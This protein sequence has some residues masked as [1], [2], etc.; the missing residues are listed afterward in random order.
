MFDCVS[1]GDSMMDVYLTLHNAEVKCEFNSEKCQICLQYGEKIPVDRMDRGLGGNAMNVSVGLSRLNYNV[2]LFTIHGDDEIGKII[3]QRLDDEKI[4]RTL[5]LTLPETNSRYSTVINF[6]GERTIL[7]YN[8]PHSYVLPESFP[9]TKWVYVSSVGKKFEDFFAAMAT[10]VAERNLS[11]A[12]TPNRAQLES[13]IESYLPLLK[14]CR[15]V[16]MNLQEAQRMM[17]KTDLVGNGQTAQVKNLLSEIFELGPKTVAIT[18][19]K[20]GAY[21]YDGS[22]YYHLGILNAVVVSAT[23]AGDAFASGFLGAI[24]KGLPTV[25]ALRW[26]TMNAGSVVGKIGAQSGLLKHDQMEK[27]LQ[28]NLGFN[29]RE[30]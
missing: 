1:V 9:E 18:D 19:G 10:L 8:M 11:V 28:E 25:E 23:G 6:K 3:D 21:V 26:G 27:I 22:K 15:A 29:P 17:N 2:A 5:S 7:E 4:D 16:F 24:M 12:F 20:N 30:I 13:P 14:L